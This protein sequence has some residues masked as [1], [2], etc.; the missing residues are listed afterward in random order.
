MLYNVLKNAWLFA[1]DFVCLI[2]F[3]KWNSFHVRVCAFLE[4]RVKHQNVLSQTRQFLAGCLGPNLW[5][6][7]R[8]NSGP[9]ASGHLSR[10]PSERHL[11]VAVDAWYRQ[12]ARF[13]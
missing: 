8:N 5:D 13:R 3:L 10:T 11:L 2:G 12:E 7:D 1:K 9:A 6:D 4:A